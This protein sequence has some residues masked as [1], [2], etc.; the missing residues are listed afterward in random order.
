MANKN[1]LKILENLIIPLG[2]IFTATFMRLVPHPPNFAPI[3]GLALFS[4][5]Y[6]KKQQAFIFPL[7]AMLVS[8]IFLGFHQTILYVYASFFLIVIIGMF[9]KKGL[10]SKHLLTASLISSLLFFLITNFGVWIATNM[11]AKDLS[12]LVSSYLMGIPFL[13]NTLLGDLFYSFSFFYGYKFVVLG[14]RKFYPVIKP[15]SL[16]QV[17]VK[18]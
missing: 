3:T 7:V 10:K 6:L 9:L 2:I 13:K 17:R 5:A 4:G 11:Y 14:M 15:L 12:G 8:D 18:E 1:L 16:N